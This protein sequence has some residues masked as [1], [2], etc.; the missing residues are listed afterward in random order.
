MTTRVYKFGG[1]S[2]GSPERI[3]AVA[4]KIAADVGS[5]QQVTVVVSA[6]GNETDRLLELARQVADTPAPRE[7]DALLATGEQAS[8][9]LL[10]MALLARGLKACSLNGS[11]VPIHTNGD[12]G[13]ARIEE[14]GTEAVRQRWTKAVSR[15]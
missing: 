2:L 7:L 8:A 13:K 9:A 10:C 12:F 11:Q 6:M 1:S 4:D 3:A 15:W 14:V 5:G